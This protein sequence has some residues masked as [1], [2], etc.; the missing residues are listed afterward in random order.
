MRAGTTLGDLLTLLLKAEFGLALPSAGALE[1]TRYSKI[2]HNPI[3]I[4][5]LIAHDSAP[6]DAKQEGRFFRG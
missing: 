1:P 3:A 2:S 4:K 6:S 5:P